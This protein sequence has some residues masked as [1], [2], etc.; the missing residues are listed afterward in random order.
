[1]NIEQHIEQ[2]EE[3]MGHEYGDVPLGF[4]I[5][6]LLTSI[7]SKHPEDIA[8]ARES[9]KEVME[10]FGG[11]YN[12]EIHGIFFSDDYD[13]RTIIHECVHGY[14]RNHWPAFINHVVEIKESLIKGKIDS[15]KYFCYHSLNE[16]IADYTAV[17]IV[18]DYALEKRMLSFFNDS[19]I[20]DEKDFLSSVKMC[21][22]FES[23]KDGDIMDSLARGLGFSYVHK[24]ML[25]IGDSAHEVLDTIIPGPKFIQ[26]MFDTVWK[27]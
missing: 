18:Q 8:E 23:K 21:N 12:P 19:G 5:E 9:I 20:L 11:V 13:D 10:N 25:E 6:E 15:D 4:T 24:K 17:K 3:F 14:V 26:E 27:Q 16:G 22:R 1:M 2:I 7:F